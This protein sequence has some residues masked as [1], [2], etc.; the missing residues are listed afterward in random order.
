MQAFRQLK[1]SLLFHPSGPESC[2]RRRHSYPSSVSEFHLSS[3]DGSE[4]PFE[5]ATLTLQRPV[6]LLNS[7]P[8]AL[9]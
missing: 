8:V 6:A 4:R 9:V 2:F 3:L 5:F 7:S 1:A